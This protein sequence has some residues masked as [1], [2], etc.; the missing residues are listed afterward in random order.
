MTAITS[1]TLLLNTDRHARVAA[2]PGAGKTYWLA[3]HVKNVLQR[4]KKIHS[5]ARIAVISYTNIA[6]D[7]LRQ[8]L[9]GD[10]AKADIGTIHN[11]LYR[12]VIK[13]YLHLLRDSNGQPVVNT[14]LVDGHDEHHVNHMKVD[15]WL[16]A[17]DQRQRV[18]DQKQFD[19]LKVALE[20]IRW[21]QAD[22]L[23]AWHLSV[24]LSDGFAK[25]L[26]ST[27]KALLT[28]QQL[29]A[30]KTLYWADGILDHDDILYF[31]SRI[32]H[33]HPLIVSCLSARYP[34][35]LI[36]EF[37]DT[38][39]VQTNIVR[40][41][42]EQG[43]TVVIIGDAEQSIFTFAGAHPEHFRA[44]TLPDTD[45]YTIADNRRSTDSIIALLN[46]VRSDSIVQHGLRRTVG[47]PVTLLVGGPAVAFQHAR[48]L[49]PD[50]ES[51]LIV[52]RNNSVVQQAQ[53]PT[54]ARTTAPWDA[55]DKADCYR[56][57]FLH[58]LLAGVVLARKQKFG[59]AV[60]TILRGI[61]HTKGNLKEPL[62]S[63]APRSTQQRRA[64][65]ISLLEALIGLGPALDS[66]T[67]FAAYDHCR[68]TLMSE[69]TGL[70]IKQ[71]KAGK[72]HDVSEAHKCG[73]L[74]LAVRL[75]GNEEVRDA[76]TIHQAKGT[77]RGNVLVCLNGRDEAETQEH[78]N[79]ILCPR[80]TSDEEQRITYVGI[81]RAR[82]RLFLTTP[83]LT[84]E[85]EQRA[86]ELG[87]QVA[88]VEKCS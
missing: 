2:G 14:T 23:C 38:V 54:T 49:L 12:N 30:Y 3:E 46:H 63:T 71:I 34:F 39:P 47:E 13:P 21:M 15:V 45:E 67:L 17:S 59:N 44:F 58:Q 88:Y 78:L 41:L 55:I 79:H 74:L 73:D 19:L 25:G 29:L 66:M 83:I 69:F 31:A 76:R 18:F 81:S 33:D 9:G 42:A 10:A 36:D 56:K 75:T 57:I 16:R 53:R 4:S 5:H 87:L 62:Q 8:K 60:E 85:Q 1:D 50:G 68:K 48:Q 37:Q 6:A 28:T 24:N 27:S 65:A 77:E 26:W 70:T 32:V 72:F 22:E 61:R 43:T 52:A 20:K 64:I 40:L 82:D 84:A 11:F 35:L 7:E 86:L 51:L 80:A